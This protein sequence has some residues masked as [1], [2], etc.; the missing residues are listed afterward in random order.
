MESD[1]TFR[2]HPHPLELTGYNTCPNCGTELSFCEIEGCNLLYEYEGWVKVGIMLQRR[3]LCR[4]HVTLTEAYK[5]NP[6][7]I[8]QLLPN[9]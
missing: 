2:R 8:E 3:R 7:V 9:V 4:E 5:K 1:I 6:K